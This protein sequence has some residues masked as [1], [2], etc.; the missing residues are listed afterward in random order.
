MGTNFET[1]F[2]TAEQPP[3][4]FEEPPVREAIAA[5]ARDTG[6]LT[7]LV[8]AG[9]GREIGLPTWEKLVRRL[10]IEAF[11]SATTDES[12]LQDIS[13]V[14]D[15]LIRLEGLLAAATLA[16]TELSNIGGRE[17]FIAALR[18][19]LYTVMEPDCFPPVIERPQTIEP[20][21]LAGALA[22]LVVTLREQGRSVHLVTT[23]YDLLLRD[24]LH[25]EIHRRNKGV[26]YQVILFGPSA[27][28]AAEDDPSTS[29]EESSQGERLDAAMP[30]EHQSDGVVRKVLYIVHL[31]GYVGIESLEQDRPIFSESE[32]YQESS[33]RGWQ[34]AYLAHRLQRSRLLVV[35][36]SLTDPDILRILFKHGNPGKPENVLGL[37]KRTRR[38]A[39]N[40]TP[41]PCYTDEKLHER[42]SL[43]RWCRIGM[44]ALPYDFY[45]EQCQF[46]VEVTQA[47]SRA[48]E[49]R[50]LRDRERDWYTQFCRDRLGFETIAPGH[51]SP[52]KFRERELGFAAR[53]KKASETARLDA[54]LTNSV[55]EIARLVEADGQRR[56]QSYGSVRANLGER[57][58]L[59]VWSRWPPGRSLAMTLCS[60]R[61][62]TSLNAINRRQL[63]QPSAFTAVNAFCDGKPRTREAGLGVGHWNLNIAV[64]IAVHDGTLPV[65]VVV[66][67]STAPRE[68]SQLMHLDQRQ[69]SQLLAILRDVGR[70]LMDVPVTGATDSADERG[71]GRESGRRKWIA[72]ESKSA[73]S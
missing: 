49:Y 23:N 3:P 44:T 33:E 46:I 15:S 16:A 11:R 71:V 66:L 61:K 2:R 53:Q 70:Q 48:E 19:A 8:G 32:Y 28:Q 51:D 68:S 43:N 38:D 69:S 14:A 52:H 37:L 25:A 13:S 26:E 57:Y 45:Y 36:A 59:H 29:P 7:I 20:G 73:N 56:P 60:D 50:D 64:P 17:Q 55:E 24:A 72:D 54:V 34:E 47:V 1:S 22:A 63:W 18:R 35:G 40:D 31:H 21:P 42:L 65:G 58:A 30:D 10:V 9:T 4:F 5:L 67:A 41:L 27:A 6:P 12:Q 39:V 62:W